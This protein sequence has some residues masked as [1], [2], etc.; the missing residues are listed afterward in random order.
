MNPQIST[1]LAFYRDGYFE[2]NFS[3]DYYFEIKKPAECSIAEIHRFYLKLRKANKVSPVNLHE[4]IFSAKYLGFCYHESDL[5][6]VSA[7]KQPTAGYLQTVYNKAGI[8]KSIDRIMLEIGYSFTEEDCRQKGISTKLKT[9][10]LTKINHYR[11]TIFSTTATPSSQRFLKANGFIPCGIPY[12]GVFDDNIV[13]FE[14]PPI[15]L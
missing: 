2:S 10:L 3:G 1:S 14:R 9:M 7:I 8:R 12:Q 5:V 13:Y 15:R 4:K 6:G 11:G